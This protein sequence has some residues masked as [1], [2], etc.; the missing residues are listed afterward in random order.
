MAKVMID[1][2]MPESCAD[3][4]YKEGEYND[5]RYTCKLINITFPAERTFR[6]R[7]CPLRRVDEE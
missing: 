6:F 3:C 4:K 2:E 7:L 5:E 1:M